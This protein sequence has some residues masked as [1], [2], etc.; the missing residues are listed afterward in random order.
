MAEEK[1]SLEVFVRGQ[2]QKWKD[3]PA[4]PT[5]DPTAPIAVV[6]VSMQPGSRGSAVAEKLAAE[7]GY[8][9][10]HR[11]MIRRIAES[12]HMSA[13]VIDSLEKER[14]SGVEDFISSLVRE[15][16]MHPDTYA[17]H[18]MKVV[19]TIAEHGRAVIVGRGANFI[20]PPGKRFAVRTMAP[21]ETRIRNVAESY[22]C[23]LEEATRRVM[24]RQ[25]RRTA[26]IR[27]TFHHDINDPLAYDLVINTERIS[28]ECAVQAI[29]A[30]MS[31]C[32]R[33]A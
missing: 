27:Q 30:A 18:L 26:F 16:Y 32:R 23:T 3:F 2:V 4:A 12:A 13:Q 1:S 11:D 25:S 5:G 8:D 7:L 6:T 20:L 10:Y 24:H 33:S 15:H 19:N 29:A 14:L 17:V 21:F 31:T 28:D 9:F 22:D